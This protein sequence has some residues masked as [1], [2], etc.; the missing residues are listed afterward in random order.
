M[1]EHGFLKN[2]ILFIRIEEMFNV[3]VLY[4]ELIIVVGRIKSPR[5][6]DLILPTTVILP[7]TPLV[8]V[9]ELL[10]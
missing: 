1:H 7:I 4:G 10:V 9:A 2:M 5:G 8:G 3:L 6:G